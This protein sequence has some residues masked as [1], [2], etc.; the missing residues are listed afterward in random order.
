[1]KLVACQIF[2]LILVSCIFHEIETCEKLARLAGKLKGNREKPKKQASI[3]HKDTTNKPATTSR[4]HADDEPA[5]SS[6]LLNEHYPEHVLSGKIKAVLEHL[7]N[8]PLDDNGKQ[9]L[10]S[11]MEEAA[12]FDALL[13]R[14]S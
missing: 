7:R 9:Q 12:Q 11:V 2:S 14:C 8:G 3:T 13:L 4:K 6:H 1:M 5:T 10:I